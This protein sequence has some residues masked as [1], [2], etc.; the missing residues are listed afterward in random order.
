MYI[1]M[2]MYMYMYVYYS[3]SLIDDNSWN[4]V[5]KAVIEIE[6]MIDVSSRTTRQFLHYKYAF[7]MLPACA[8]HT[9]VYSVQ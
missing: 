7:S 8:L 5:N 3:V 9:P 4:V 2:Y 6:F 1:N